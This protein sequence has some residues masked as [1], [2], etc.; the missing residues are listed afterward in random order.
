MPLEIAVGPQKLVINQGI[1]FLVTE[2]GGELYALLVDQV[3]EVMSLRS[4]TFERT[5][6][7]LPGD[8]FLS[9]RIEGFVC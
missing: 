5:P 4:S 7:T 6:P 9:M 3:R 2:Q 8:C 1:G